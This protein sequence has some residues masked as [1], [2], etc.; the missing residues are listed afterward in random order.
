MFAT[1]V[2][3]PLSAVPARLRVFY[4][5]NPLAGVVENFRRILLENQ[6]PDFVSLW[7]AAIVSLVALPV[8]YLIFRYQEASMAD[9]I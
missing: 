4:I 7:R 9:V 2:V 6:P 3:Y 8:C 1:P 5:L